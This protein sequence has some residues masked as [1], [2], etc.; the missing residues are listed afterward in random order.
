MGWQVWNFV[1]F[2]AFVWK[3]G[4]SPTKLLKLRFWIHGWLRNV[5]QNV[6]ELPL[7]VKIRIS[8]ELKMAYVY[9]PI[10]PRWQMNGYK[11]CFKPIFYWFQKRTF[12]IL[13]YTQQV[14]VLC[15]IQKL[16]W[17]VLCRNK[18]VRY[19]DN[20]DRYINRDIYYFMYM[21]TWQE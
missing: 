4:E 18:N 5:L 14:E 1:I 19:R 21:Q 16:W 3:L 13:E 17:L 10:W 8:K 15:W 12:C 2:L 20:C 11:M 7:H 6:W 9:L